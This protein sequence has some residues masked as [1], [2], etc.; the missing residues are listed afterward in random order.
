MK[1]LKNVKTGQVMH[2]N[3][4]L[5][6]KKE[7]VPCEAPVSKKKVVPVTD[8]GRDT[9]GNGLISKEKGEELVQQW[10]GRDVSKVTKNDIKI[11]AIE[12]DVDEL[13]PEWTKLEMVTRLATLL[14]DSFMPADKEE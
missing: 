9:K 2:W 1:F 4:R 12:N 5:A 14:G 11:F 8:D 7:M 13:K 6:K 10:F 3:K